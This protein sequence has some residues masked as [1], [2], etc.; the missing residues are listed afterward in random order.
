MSI[1]S[2]AVLL[3]ALGGFEF[4]KWA[5]NRY[6]FRRQELV[7]S[8]ATASKAAVEAEKAVRDMYEDTIKELRE[9][10]IA[11][12]EELR[13]ANKELNDYN[14]EL[15][16]SGAKKDEI[17]DDKTNKIRDLQDGRVKD[18]KTIGE[19]SKQLLH[20]K[21]WFCK[22]ESGNGKNECTRRIP[23]QNPPLKYTPLD[24]E[25]L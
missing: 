8:S 24:Q 3:T 20:Y 18:A 4:V 11:R 25:S 22:R 7:K 16:K 14:L 9:E 21:S 15:I 13:Q 23:A 17:I 1:E 6:V 2:L 12:I 10:Y 19:L 5:V